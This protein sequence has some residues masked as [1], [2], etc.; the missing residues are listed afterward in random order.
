MLSGM[1]ESPLQPNLWYT[2]NGRLLCGL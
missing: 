1:M 2:Y